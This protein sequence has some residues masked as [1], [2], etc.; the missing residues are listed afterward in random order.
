MPWL[1]SPAP[2]LHGQPGN[3]YQLYNGTVQMGFALGVAINGERH[4]QWLATHA[5]LG[6]P[7]ILNTQ[8]KQ[9]RDD[10]I[11]LSTLM[12]GGFD[13]ATQILDLFNEDIADI[14]RHPANSPIIS[15]YAQW[16]REIN[17]IYIVITIARLSTDAQ[18]FL[19][20][21]VMMTDRGTF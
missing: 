12:F 8:T 1:V 21:I 11:V 19:Q 20:E 9:D 3:T 6:D 10:F 17:G 2:T 18:E 13:S 4:M 16:Q 7:S 5:P 14:E 15:E